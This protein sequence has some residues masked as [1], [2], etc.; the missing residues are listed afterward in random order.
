MNFKSRFITILV[1]FIFSLLIF[2]PSSWKQTAAEKVGLAGNPVIE[3]FIDRK[4]TLGL[5]LQGGTQLD[6][7]V[8]LRDVPA[9]DQKTI[10]EGVRAVFERRVN[11]LGVS[12]PNIYQ[13]TLG[14]EE[15]LIVEL[16]GINDIN[17][18]KKTIGQVIQLEFKEQNDAQESD[19]KEQTKTRAN[20]TLKQVVN[21]PEKFEVTGKEVTLNDR[22]EYKKN[23]LF[24]DGIETLLQEKIKTLKENQVHPELL[25][26]TIPASFEVVGE[27]LKQVP[28]KKGFFIVK[29]GKAEK[30]LRQD[31]VNAEEFMKV[32][33]EV[34]SDQKI[35]LGYI[36]KTELPQEVQDKVF[37]LGNKNVSDVLETADGYSIFKMVEKLPADEEMVRAQDILLKF[38]EIKETKV[39]DP[40]LPEAERQKLE[41]ENTKIQE[42]N[43]AANQY[44]QEELPK[45]AADVL[46]RVKAE[47]AKFNEFVQQFSEDTGSKEKNGDL[48][49][50]GSGKFP[51]EQELEAKALT[52]NKGELVTEPVKTSTGYHIFQ[53]VDK[54]AA[55]EEVA[56]L[57]QIRICF[58]GAANC[59]ATLSKEDAQ[60]KA[61]ETLR[62]VREETRYTY[63]YIYYSTLPDQWKSALAKNF[64][65]E[66]EPLTGKFFK[67][68]D[69][70]YNSTTGEPIVSISFNDEG[71]RMFEDLTGRM[72]GQP[73][74]I[75][76][77]G[78]LISAPNVNEKIAGG[79][80]TISGSFGTEE[81]AKLARDLNAGAIPAPIT[82]VGEQHI[83]GQ[84][85]QEALAASVKAGIWGVLALMLFLIL[86]YRLPGVVASVALGVYVVI[87]I[88]FIKLWPGMV[89]TLAGIAGVILSIGVAVDANVLIF[90][91]VR[92]EL[93]LGKSLP[94][95]LKAGF[96]RAWTS[97]RDSNSSS[98]LTALI[99]LWFGSSII[100]GFAFMLIAGVVLSL[101]SAIYTT[102][103]LLQLFTSERFNKPGLWGAKVNKT[104]PVETQVK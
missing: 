50:F 81:A 29:L 90:E 51:N 37:A 69:V 96:D 59:S 95:A 98:I 27:E 25:E 19:Q 26:G 5:D 8:D 20:E 104:E 31:P 63:E 73:L 78:E 99:L 33:Q 86:Y 67:H 10:I 65:G 55:N 41:E 35:D 68:A 100:K 40:N 42:E 44:N 64:K 30:M 52:M 3:W 101:F 56:K 66:L 92:E 12:E 4:V 77:G 36:R 88:A 16:A 49:F 83:G 102:R 58:S 28:E 89:L 61:E 62:R 53:I 6:Y 71:G 45:K 85:G 46:A 34:R 70:E 75:F 32:A 48:G 7:K 1:V 47:P 57:E 79:L 84:L 38:R 13:S 72:T 21:T 11:G 24:L 15:H 43:N 103:T 74:A 18:A 76:V 22:I 2:L 87:F 60:K 93:A 9:K 94:L 80:A 82:L 23:S 54:K 97:I 39:I 91:R 17:E 14:N